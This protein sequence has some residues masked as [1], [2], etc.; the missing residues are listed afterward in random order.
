MNNNIDLK[1]MLDTMVVLA[2]NGEFLGQFILKS[3]NEDTAKFQNEI[4]T[5][6]IAIKDIEFKDGHLNVNT[7]E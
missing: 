5:L 4:G 7:M 2:E 1:P 6:D 3:I